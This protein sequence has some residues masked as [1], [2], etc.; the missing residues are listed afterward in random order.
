MTLIIKKTGFED[1]LAK[2]GGAYIKVLILGEPDAGKTRSASFWP[3]PLILDCEQ[4]RMSIADRGVDYAEIKSSRDMDAAVLRVKQEGLKPAESRRWRTL[5]WDTASSYQR[6]L[7]RERLQAERKESL[8]GWADWGFLDGKMQ[9]TLQAV[10]NLPMNV[11]VNVHITDESDGDDE[12]K[13]LVKKPKLKGDIR[14]AIAADFDLIGYLEKSYVADGGKRVLQRQVRWHSEPRYPLAKDRSGRLPRF[15]D[16]DFTEDDYYRVYNAIVGEHVD[17][18]PAS[19]DVEELDTGEVEPAAPDVKGGP[20]AVEP[21][22]LPRAAKKTAAKKTAAKKTE[23]EP[24][25]ATKVGAGPQAGR[26]SAGDDGSSPSPAQPSAE[27]AQDDAVTEEQGVANVT[28][29]LGATPVQDPD[30]VPPTAPTATA[31]AAS[32]APDE[33]AVDGAPKCGDQPNHFKKFDAAKGCGKGLGDESRDRINLA[34]LRTKTYLCGACFT[35]W[36]AA[37]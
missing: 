9:Q 12:S 29:A 14:T 36:K 22:P 21:I 31:E 28:E 26:E 17:A 23:P 15:T 1:Y 10:L 20:V 32:A 37:R 18:F 27:P 6:I 13:M 7:I 35:A 24:E 11:V 4:G 3:A 16:V 5:V 33:P 30:D 25:P 19:V 34:M 8:S 2:L